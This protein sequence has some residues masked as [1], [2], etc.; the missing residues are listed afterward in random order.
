MAQIV[1]GDGHGLSPNG[2]ALPGFM[3]FILAAVINNRDLPA[4]SAI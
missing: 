2:L 3:L 1:P 4:V